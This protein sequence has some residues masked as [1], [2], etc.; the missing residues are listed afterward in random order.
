MKVY[1]KAVAENG[2]T[3]EEYHVNGIDGP[4]H[5]AHG[6]AFTNRRHDGIVIEEKYYCEGK[7]HRDGAPAVIERSSNDGTVSKEEYWRNGVLHRDDG[8]AVVLRNPDGS[9]FGQKQWRDGRFIPA[10]DA[11]SSPTS[12]KTR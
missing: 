3:F 4:L 5:N 7:L 10:A 6:P 9:E 8:P 11:K 12:A 1:I 2:Q